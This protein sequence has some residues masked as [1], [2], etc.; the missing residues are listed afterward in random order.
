M[1]ITV[2]ESNLF[3]EIQA[4]ISKRGTQSVG[5]CYLPSSQKASYLYLYIPSL[6]ERSCDRSIIQAVHQADIQ[7]QIESGE[8][9]EGEGV[10]VQNRIR[11][12]AGRV[13]SCRMKSENLDVRFTTHLFITATNCV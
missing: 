4:I 7:I 5:I 9:H 1:L 2:N 11:W 8:G 13:L 12:I 6:N 10:L 3:P